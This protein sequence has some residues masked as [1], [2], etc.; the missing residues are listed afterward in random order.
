MNK[1]NA[2]EGFVKNA[3]PVPE[4]IEPVEPDYGPPVTEE[5]PPDA[6]PV[7]VR[8]MHK[9][10]RDNKGNMLKELTFREPTGGDI[11]RHG[12]PCHVDQYGDVIILD[13]KMITMMAVLSGVLQP[14]L[15]NMDPRD[16]NSC[17]Y[18]LRGFFIPNPE[19]W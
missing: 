6:W 9:A 15:E 13:R 18:R 11:N 14:F 12:N 5:P 19:A 1:Q 3:E 8:L 4:V 7:T 10:V 16:Y 2:K 17:A